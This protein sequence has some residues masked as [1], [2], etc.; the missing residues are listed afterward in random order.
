MINIK[1]GII[2]ILL[3]AFVSY[4]PAYAQSAVNSYESNTGYSLK[5]PNGW[6][7]QE[8]S[9]PFNVVL[10]K[11]PLESKSDNFSENVNVIVEKAPGYTTEQYYQAN[12]KSINQNHTLKNFKILES[13]NKIIYGK[14]GKYL[15][16]THTY[17]NTPLKVKAYFF[18]N[19]ENGYV[20][21]CTAKPETFN[22]YL[23][24]FE[25]IVSTFKLVVNGI[26]M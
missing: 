24:T 11:S 13:G 8:Q 23:P 5:Y 1:K 7:T 26:H 15:I 2:T 21:T 18:T 6:T 4:S 22:T 9:S 19:G 10:F 20:I 17:N 14:T 12:I 16:Y 25:N 3:T